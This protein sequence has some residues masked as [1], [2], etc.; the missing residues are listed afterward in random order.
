[1]LKNTKTKT[2]VFVAALATIIGIGAS[3]SFAAPSRNTS[4]SGTCYNGSSWTLTM[5]RSGNNVTTSMVITKMPKGSKWNINYAYPNTYQVA[6]LSAIA[7]KKGTVSFKNSIVS[8]SEVYSLVMVDSWGTG[9]TYC[10]AGGT[11]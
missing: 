8:S 10:I 11:K 6:N 3:A 1:M 2:L 4:W 9:I 7:D 5:S